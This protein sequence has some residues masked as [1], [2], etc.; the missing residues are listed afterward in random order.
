MTF[1]GYEWYNDVSMLPTYLLW[2]AGYFLLLFG[3]II[4]HEI[5]NHESC[6]GE[7]GTA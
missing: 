7:L 6:D 2:A 4:F 5:G 1:L 3:C